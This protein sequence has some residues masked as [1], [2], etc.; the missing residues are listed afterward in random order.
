MPFRLWFRL[1][2]EHSRLTIREQPKLGMRSP[3]VLAKIGHDL[4][5][6][7]DDVIEEPLPEKV[8]RAVANLPTKP[9]LRVVSASPIKS[10]SR[11]S[12]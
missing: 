4:R 11:L 10:A 9:K 6:S 2:P 8:Q 7:Y 5:H 1:K 3:F 12:Q